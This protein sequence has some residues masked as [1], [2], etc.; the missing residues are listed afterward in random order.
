[1]RE[2][3][4]WIVIIIAALLLISH[5]ERQQLAPVAR[6]RRL[7]SHDYDMPAS[8][9]TR[10]FADDWLP[11]LGGAGDH[12]WVLARV[13]GILS[14]QGGVRCRASVPV[15]R[16]RLS[17]ALQLSSLHRSGIE[18]PP[19]QFAL[20]EA[21]SVR[22]A[23]KANIMMKN[24]ADLSISLV[25]YTMVGYSLSFTEGNSFVGGFSK[26]FLLGAD[27]EL[28]VVLHQFSFAATTG[29]IGGPQS[30]HARRRRA[31]GVS[32][33]SLLARCTLSLADQLCL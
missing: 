3:F 29:T 30:P 18:I 2:P 7:F 31:S 9:L 10:V 14:M 15:S 32:G 21:G 19:P 22:P 8:N 13:V 26:A 25:G 28:T 27:S 17:P 4:V 11:S 23:N 5:Y 24:V 16:L 6:Q 12:S 33:G 20:L 1:M